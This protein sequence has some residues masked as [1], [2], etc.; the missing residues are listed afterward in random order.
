MDD[1]LNILAK[2]ANVPQATITIRLL[3]NAIE[4]E[5]DLRLGH[6]AEQRVNDGSEY[7]LNKDEFWK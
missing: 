7:I 3:R 1:H 2:Q 6:I 4:L 5:E